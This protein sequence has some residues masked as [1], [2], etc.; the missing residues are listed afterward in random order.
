[1]RFPIFALGI[2]AVIGGN[3]GNIMFF[4]GI[5]KIGI[6]RILRLYIINILLVEPWLFLYI[7]HLDIVGCHLMA[8][9]LEVEIILK[10]IAVAQDCF[11]EGI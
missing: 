6:V 4:G 9:Q 3:K 2:V 10:E 1:M 5:Y 8:L 11:M 7:V